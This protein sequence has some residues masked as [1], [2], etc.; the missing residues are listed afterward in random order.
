MTIMLYDLDTLILS[1]MLNT[2]ELRAYSL[3]YDY[4]S[5][6][7]RRHR[8]SVRFIHVHSSN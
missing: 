7:R 6:W 4:V 1:I 2:L 8:A 3:N 5:A